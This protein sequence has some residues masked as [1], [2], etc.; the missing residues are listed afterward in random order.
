M[1]SAGI[2]ESDLR[3]IL[4]VGPK[5][6]T[7]EEFEHTLA[8]FPSVSY[9]VGDCRRRSDMIRAGVVHAHTVLI[10]SKPENSFSNT[11][12]YQV[13]EKPTGSM[14]N[15]TASF[16]DSAAVMTTHVVSQILASEGIALNEVQART[17]AAGSDDVTRGIVGPV[18]QLQESRDDNYGKTEQDSKQGD[19][20]VRISHDS[21]ASVTKPISSLHESTSPSLHSE[22]TEVSQKRIKRRIT[23]ITELLDRKNIRFLHA[24]ECSTQIID[25]LHSPVYA[26]GQAVISAL[27]DSFLCAVYQNAAT[28]PIVQA[29][30][31]DLA[32]QDS[33]TLPAKKHDTTMPTVQAATTG[34]STCPV[35]EAWHKRTF[36]DL[37]KDL[38]TRKGIVVLGLLRAPSTKLGNALPFVYCNPVTSLILNKHDRLFVL[39]P[40]LPGEKPNDTST[41]PV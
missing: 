31:G 19:G 17:N 1:R 26:S 24:L 41:V 8:V 32:N 7:D 29:L 34:L 22:N 3:H 35:G 37:Y 39:D 28:I 5:E 16:A 33:T 14:D 38:A 36:G 18:K 21:Q 25:H 11:D 6:P 23:V 40:R 4:V 15:V 2:P 12:G 30:C 27:L 9:L 13:N 20:S 10:M